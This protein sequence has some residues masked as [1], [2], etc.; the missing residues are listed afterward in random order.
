MLIPQ[1][2]VV[3]QGKLDPID[4]LRKFWHHGQHCDTD[5]ILQ[6]SRMGLSTENKHYLLH[7]KMFLF[8]SLFLICL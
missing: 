5:E 1:A 4:N 2:D 3:L 8:L 6:K 7:T